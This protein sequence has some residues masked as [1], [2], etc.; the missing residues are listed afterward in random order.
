VKTETTTY[1]TKAVGLELKAE[2]TQCTSSCLIA[3]MQD[4]IIIQTFLI[5]PLKMAQKNSYT[6]GMMVTNQ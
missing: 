3:R 5:N 6:W 4:K 1:T 2:K